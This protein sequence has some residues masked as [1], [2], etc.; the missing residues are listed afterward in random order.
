MSEEIFSPQW[1]RIA[2]LQPRLRNH[3]EVHR[4]HYRGELWYLLHD[5]QNGRQHRFT[6]AAHH[7]LSLMDGQRSVQQVWDLA[8]T[9]L[10]DDAPTQGETLRLL[11]ELHGSDLLL[12][13][14]PVDTA[15]LF[16]RQQ[17]QKR[18]KARQR[19]LNPMSVRLPLWD[20]Q[21]FLQRFD[22]AAAL[23]FSPWGAVLWLLVVGAALTQVFSHWD[24]LTHNTAD[25]V[26]APSNL[27]LL[28]VI[29]PVVKL[30]HELGH[31]FAVRRWGGEVHELGVML[32]VFVPVP[33][34]DASAATAFGGKRRRMLV[35]A[36]GILTELLIAAAATFVWLAVEPGAVRAVAFNVMLIA[37]VSTLVFNA[38]PLLRFDG[39]FIFSDWVEIPNLAGRASQYLGYLFQRYVFGV[40]HLEPAARSAGERA[41]LASYGVAAFV[42]RLMVSV[43]IVLFVSEKFFVVGIVLALWALLSMV[44]LPLAKVLRQVLTSP[45]IAPHRARA[46]LTLSFTALIVLATLAFVPVPLDTRAEGVVWLPA[47]ATVRASAAGFVR[48]LRQADGAAVQRGELLADTEDPLL[49]ARATVLAYKVQELQARYNAQWVSDVAKAGVVAQALAAA[50]DELARAQQQVDNQLIRSPAAGRL[51]LPHA[52]D[53][54]GQWLRQGDV[55]GYVVQPPLRSVLAVVAQDR[56]GLVRERTCGVEL[57][58][59]AAPGRLL[60]A[61]ITREVPAASDELPSAALGRAGGGEI[62]IRPGDEQGIKAFDSVFQ[63]EL[64]LADGA[65]FDTLGSRVWLRFD[66]GAEPLL[67]QGWRRLRQLFLR[68]YGV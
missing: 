32:L 22:T 39:Y 52:A 19:W 60:H 13:D 30:L 9:H 50:Q 25:A 2:G 53:L 54:P 28:F 51:L 65:S 10:G 63:F 49:A 46:V 23:V 26:L 3:V 15:E 48:A 64:R 14:V 38:N 29:Y 11:G 33:Y 24:E 45:A 57:R 6:P 5:R 27:L 18:Q 20:P 68:R 44:L 7:L 43:V 55:V 34:V 4:H 47:N 31:A 40:E 1:Y 58:T 35:S 41:W 56:I 42:Y 12:C 62:A 16:A 36:A 8:N 21:R 17:R 66:H 37:G 59:A 61:A 67:A